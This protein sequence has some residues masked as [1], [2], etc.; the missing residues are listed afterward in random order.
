MGVQHAASDVSQSVVHTGERSEG[1]LAVLECKQDQA[2]IKLI[3]PRG[4][5]HR[6]EASL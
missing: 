5:Q 6:G 3:E 1:D 4:L 2:G